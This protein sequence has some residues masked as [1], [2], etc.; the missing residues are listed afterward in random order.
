MTARPSRSRNETWV[1]IPA[2]NEAEVIASVVQKVLTF[3]Y[4]VV[5]VDD[6]SSDDTAA[7]LSRLP[8]HFCHHVF[9]LGQGAALQTGIAYA[10]AKN[11]QYIVTF[12]SDGQHRAEEIERLLAPLLHGSADVAL[13]TRFSGEG[14]AVNI[15][16]A[17]RF[18]LKV[19][20]M[21]TKVFTRLDVTDTH[22][23][24][25]AFTHDA[26]A[27]IQI[28]Q[29]RMS[30]ATQILSEIRGKHL[31]YIEVPVTIDYSEYSLT[32]GQKISNSFNI[33]WDTFMEFLKP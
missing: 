32:K 31:R 5:V 28:T 21:F 22:N 9:N 18:V 3:G 23:G 29:N 26:A 33:V 12:D 24:F 30:H 8:V 6:C 27:K 4:S 10:L 7:R 13:G 19:A 16:P 1:V 2:F 25:R 14:R 11:A 20:T 15:P 17:K